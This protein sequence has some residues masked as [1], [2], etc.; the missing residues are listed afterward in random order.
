MAMFDIKKETD[1]YMYIVDTGV[2][3]RSVTNDAR[4]VV[5]Y[6]CKHYNLKNRRLIYRD[7]CGSIDEIKHFYG[8]F[9][10]YAPGHAG[11]D[12]LPS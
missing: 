12:D 11:I 4:D 3:E 5:Y 7:S 8:T 6:L 2:N 1:E 10:E 9:L